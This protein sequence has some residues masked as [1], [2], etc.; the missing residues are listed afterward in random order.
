LAKVETRRYSDRR[1]YLIK[2]VNKRRKKIRQMAV[3]Y[4]GGRCE[5]CGYTNCIEAL[6]FHHPDPSGKDFCV[7]QK[8][9]TRSY[10]KGNAGIGQMSNT[11]RQLSPRTSCQVSSLHGKL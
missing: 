1:Q 5:K 3:D 10:R 11:V 8:G 4:K 7:S 6:E 2:A 9:Y